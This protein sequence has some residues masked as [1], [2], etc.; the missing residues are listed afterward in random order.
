M[1]AVLLVAEH[2]AL[3]FLVIGGVSCV[4]SFL[5]GLAA[6]RHGGIIE[7]RTGIANRGIVGRSEFRWDEIASFDHVG[8]RVFVRL[9]DGD[10][11]PLVGVA[12]GQ[13]TKWND[14]ETRD[15]V[16]VLNE[17]LESRRSADLERPRVVDT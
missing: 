5:L 1:A 7:G 13:R 15:I 14:G 9:R 10:V 12:Q 17:R 3:I 11:R 6:M 4:L 16:S 2:A 8:A